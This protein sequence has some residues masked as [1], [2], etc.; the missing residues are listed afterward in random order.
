MFLLFSI[1]YSFYEH[2]HDDGS[3]RG[4]K[5]RDLNK[6]VDGTD[7]MENFIN[8]ALNECKNV[9][10]KTGGEKYRQWYSGK[11]DGANWCAT[12]VSWCADRGW[13]IRYSYS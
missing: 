5:W 9:A 2:V 1:L 7:S 6:T 12:F 10:G 11:A 8:I 13:Y 4:R 3:L